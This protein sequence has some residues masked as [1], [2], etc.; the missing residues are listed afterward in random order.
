M[1]LSKKERTIVTFG[2]TE[3]HPKDECGDNAGYGPN[4]TGSENASANYTKNT[5]K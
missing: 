4:P 3:N 5:G 2:K 1:K